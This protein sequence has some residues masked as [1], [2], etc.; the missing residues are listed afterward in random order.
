LTG[1]ACI[2]PYPGPFDVKKFDMPNEPKLPLTA[3][4]LQDFRRLAGIMVPPAM[5]FGVPGADDH[6]IFEDIV[7]SLGR[8]RDAVRQALAQ[9]R[10][11]AGGDFCGL[12]EP[13]AQTTAMALLDRHGPIVIAL[14]RAVLQCYYRDGRVMAA[15]GLEAKRRS[16]KDIP[17]SLAIGRCWTRSVAGRA[18]GA[19]SMMLTL[20]EVSG[21]DRS[22]F[23]PSTTSNRRHRRCLDHRLRRVRRGRDT[24][25]PVN[26][27]A[28]PM[29]VA[30]FNGVG[31]GTIVYTAHF[32]RMHPS[33]FKVRTLD[34]VA[35]DWAVKAGANCCAPCGRWSIRNPTQGRGACGCAWAPHKPSK[36]GRSS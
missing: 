21:L 8:D 19:T 35:D 13:R 29:K 12:D 2:E 22:G 16:P 3:A 17:L 36:M 34:G 24:D 26:D 5:E 14:G 27:D 4:E 18:C 10:E 7:R 15:L 30:N 6:M 9:L 1:V 32:P 11:M 33:D 25:Y 23:S 20:F 31:G 28:S